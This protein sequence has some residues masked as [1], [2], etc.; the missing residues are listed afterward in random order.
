MSFADAVRRLLEAIAEHRPY[1]QVRPSTPQPMLAHFHEW[2]GGLTIP[3]LRKRN[4]PIATVFTTHATLLGRYIA[5]S[6]DDFYDQLPWLDQEQEAR[7]YNVVTQ[8]KI[9]RA[10]AHG[11]HV[12]TTVSSVTAEECNYLLGRPVDVVTPN[13]LTI[14]LYNAGHDQQRLHGEYKEALHKFYDGALFPQ[15]LLRPG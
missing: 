7:H 11:A 13:G 1:A 9:E 10:C 15:L 6:R 5:S 3:M 8:H 14:G 2:L 4:L 12:F